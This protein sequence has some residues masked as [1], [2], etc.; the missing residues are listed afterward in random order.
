MGKNN[1]FFTKHLY[2]AVIFILF[3]AYNLYAQND[4]SNSEQKPDNDIKTE[5]VI[6]AL[7]E[8]FSLLN[9]NIGKLRA[10]SERLSDSV[11]KFQIWQVISAV[12]LALIALILLSGSVVFLWMNRLKLSQFFGAGQKLANEKQ[13]KD[14]F[15]ESKPASSGIM[16][17]EF[18]E[19]KYKFDDIQYQI[20]RLDDEIKRQSKITLQFQNDLTFLK[21]EMSDLK[22]TMVN[23][24]SNFSSLKTEI[25]KNREKLIRKE[26]V[27]RDP[28]YVF[29]QWAQNPHLPLP[30]YF[31]YVNITK[32]EFRIKQEFFDTRTETEWI[33][34]TIS[35][36][37]YL[38]PNPNKINNLSGPIDKFYKVT[39]TRKA[40]GLNSI[41]II[42]PCEIKEDN[43]IEFQGNLLIL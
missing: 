10:S 30:E 1:L 5:T 35:E 33:R 7:E 38:F 28:V 2:F 41:K 6:P 9:N 15:D 32:L 23:A 3:G 16:P 17:S 4:S 37:K 26:Q 36:R 42:N 19:L 40:E 13:I 25:E 43:Y 20:T 39:G 34:N 22:Q 18:N 31:T 11:S 14:R 8:N 29:N 12:S 24:N 27:E 21:T